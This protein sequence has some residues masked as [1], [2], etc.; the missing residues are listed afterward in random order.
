MSQKQGGFRMRTMGKLIKVW[1]GWQYFA[2]GEGGVHLRVYCFTVLY[3][4][5]LFRGI[6]FHSC[7]R[8]NGRVKAKQKLSTTV[9]PEP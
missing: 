7:A 8:Q 5:S 3:C 4:F 1:C 2:R 9:L 6:A